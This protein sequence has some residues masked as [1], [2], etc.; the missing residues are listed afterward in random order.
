MNCN[1]CYLKKRLF[2][3]CD[4]FFFQHSPLSRI[5]H[6]RLSLSCTK[7]TLLYHTLLLSLSFRSEERLFSLSLIILS[8]LMLLLL[9]QHYTRPPLSCHSELLP[10][11]TQSYIVEPHGDAEATQRW[12]S[13]PW[14][15]PREL[16]WLPRIKRLWTTPFCC[17]WYNTML[18][19]C[20]WPLLRKIKRRHCRI[21]DGVSRFA[22]GFLIFPWPMSY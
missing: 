15:I 8:L 6:Y 17:C 13:H 3:V 19:I 22:W 16:S 21:S 9:S 1:Y 11:G 5:T 10:G 20:T 2:I 4:V 14:V 12:G 7:Q 18:P